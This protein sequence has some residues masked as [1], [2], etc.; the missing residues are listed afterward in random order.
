MKLNCLK[1]TDC[2][3]IFFNYYSFNESLEI[4][5]SGDDKSKLLINYEN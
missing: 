2:S 1:S 5:I 3:E 4:K